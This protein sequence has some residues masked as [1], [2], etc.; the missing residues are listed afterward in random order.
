MHAPHGDGR[1]GCTIEASFRA[2]ADAVSNR[3]GRSEVLGVTTFT[4]DVGGNSHNFNGRG[5]FHEQIQSDPRFTLPFS[6]LTLRGPDL[7]LIAIRGPRGARG[8]LLRAEALTEIARIELTPPG[9]SRSVAL[10]GA[11]GSVTGGRLETTCDYSIP[12]FD[13]YRPGTLVAGE[14]GG[15]PVSGCVNDFL[16]DQLRFDRSPPENPDEASS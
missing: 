12:V 5:Q 9:S 4:I 3:A 1:Y 15:V 6:Y 14:I 16:V 7:G 13:G 10:H 8:H 11:D 2:A